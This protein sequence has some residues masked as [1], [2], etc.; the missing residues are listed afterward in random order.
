MYKFYFAYALAYF[1]S[2]ILPSLI[3]LFVESIFVKPQKKVHACLYLNLLKIKSNINCEEI[4]SRKI[5][6][7]CHVSYENRWNMVMKC[8]YNGC[9]DS[10]YKGFYSKKNYI[11]SC[12]L[13]GYVN[14]ILV[15]IG[16]CYIVPFVFQWSH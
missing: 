4:K 1:L 8:T 2:I 7:S 15:Y 5:I 3:S 9:P 10:R 12:W 16:R 14:L 11:I 13:H 6:T